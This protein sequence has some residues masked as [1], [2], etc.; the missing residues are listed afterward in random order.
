MSVPQSWTQARSNDPSYLRASAQDC[1]Y[2]DQRLFFTRGRLDFTAPGRKLLGLPND[3]SN[4][5]I[6]RKTLSELTPD[7]YRQFCYKDCAIYEKAEN[8][9]GSMPMSIFDDVYREWFPHRAREQDLRYG[10]F[11]GKYMSCNPEMFL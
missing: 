11:F 6:I 7:D 8:L 2:E 1:H 5:K 9:G 10:S 4:Y 3:S